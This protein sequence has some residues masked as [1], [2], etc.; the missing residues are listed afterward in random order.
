MDVSRFYRGACRRK[1]RE[2]L[3]G[4][5]IRGGDW[6]F[7]ITLAKLNPNA[8]ITEVDWAPVLAV[9]TEND[10]GGRRG[11]DRVSFRPGSAFEPTG[12]GLRCG[13]A[14]ETSF[15]I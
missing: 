5:D 9:A 4:L 12:R 3:Q 11:S 7:G 10:R 1:G 8:Q 14:D 13:A 2:N 6:E 15:N